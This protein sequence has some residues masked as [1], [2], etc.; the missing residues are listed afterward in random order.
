MSFPG[1]MNRNNRADQDLD[2]E[3]RAGLR[4]VQDTDKGDSEEID[5]DFLSFF[6]FPPCRLVPSDINIPSVH[7]QKLTP[8]S[9]RLDRWWTDSDTLPALSRT[10]YSVGGIE[11]YVYVCM[12]LSTDG[13]HIMA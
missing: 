3:S 7:I 13:V 2:Q 11:L 8:A 1:M 12:V 6:P 5:C 9:M 4:N 10:R